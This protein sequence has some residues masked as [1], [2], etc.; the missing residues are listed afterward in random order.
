MFEARL[1]LQTHRANIGGGLAMAR[2]KSVVAS[3]LLTN[4]LLAG[5]I[6]TSEQRHADQRPL[7]SDQRPLVSDQRPADQRPAH[8][9]PA[10]QRPAD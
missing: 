5:D 10:D 2:T 7:I 1:R 8:W 6:Q 4:D 3:A 9:R